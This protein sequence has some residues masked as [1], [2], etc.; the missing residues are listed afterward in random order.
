MSPPCP[1]QRLPGPCSSRVPWGKWGAGRPLCQGVPLLPSC[2]V[3]LGPAGPGSGLQFAQGCE[4]GWGPAGHSGKEFGFWGQMVT[5][6]DPKSALCCCLPLGKSSDLVQIVCSAIKRGERD[7]HRMVRVGHRQ[8]WAQSWLLVNARGCCCHAFEWMRQLPCWTVNLR[9]RLHRCWSQGDSERHLPGGPVSPGQ[10]GAV[11]A[12]GEQSCSP[13]ETSWAIP[14]PEAP[15]T[16]YSR[17]CCGMGVEAGSP[18]SRA[19]R[20]LCSRP[21]RATCFFFLSYLLGAEP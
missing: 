14:S 18:K 19:G 21:S 13:P 17:G 2:L 20:M 5:C 4:E 15:H 6:L 11:K 3:G 16:I 8:S 10:Q 9:L 7:P 1:G 12:V